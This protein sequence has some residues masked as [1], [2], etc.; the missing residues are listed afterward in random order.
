[1]GAD[2]K[3]PPLRERCQ[4]LTKSD[5]F[6]FGFDGDEFNNRI[7][8]SAKYWVA[9]GQPTR[10]H[11]GFA[12]ELASAL[13]EIR[14][15]IG[16]FSIS[17]SSSYIISA[18]AAISQRSRCQL[19]QVVID[20]AGFRPVVHDK[21]IPAQRIDV[22]WEQ[23]AEFAL[24]FA[25]VAG[26]P[27]PWI[28]LEA[29]HGAMSKLPHL[30][31]GAELR[32][33]NNNFDPPTRTIVGPPDWSLV[34]NEK[35]TAIDRYLIAKGRTGVSQLLRWSPELVA[36]QIDSPQTRSWL[37][38]ASAVRAS[39]KSSG[40]LNQRARI[41]MVTAA[42]PD[43]CPAPD[44]RR[45][46]MDPELEEEMTALGKR[47]RRLSPDCQSQHRYPLVRLLKKFGIEFDFLLDRDPLRYGFVNE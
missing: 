1:V 38:R 46:R 7:S 43:L 34:D 28:A 31:D 2:L 19:S 12:A 18:V 20:F 44:S 35:F 40:W 13:D 47:M 21:R 5:H 22:E 8:S 17:A 9:Y 37:K 41:Q 11:R 36:A 3:R 23:F 45:S 33:I 4:F 27:D 16:P 15:S 6:K 32:I 10:R 14:A 25:T 26:C 30:Y 29:F 39:I 24:K 42:F